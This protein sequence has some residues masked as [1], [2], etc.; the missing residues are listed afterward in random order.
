MSNIG[1]Y[2][3]KIYNRRCFRAAWTADCGNTMLKLK[4]QKCQKF[5]S[6]V[7]CRALII[8]CNSQDLKIY[9]K[10]NLLLAENS[11]SAVFKFG[12]LL[13]LLNINLIKQDKSIS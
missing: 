7:S 1:L 8:S 10:S 6:A 4:M 12:G 5:T 11:H 2:A 9:T 13:R 3:K